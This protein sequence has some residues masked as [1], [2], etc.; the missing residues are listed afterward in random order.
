M[1]QRLPAVFLVALAA[2][3]G[4]ISCE[5]SRSE[6]PIVGVAVHGAREGFTAAFLATV[7]KRADGRVALAVMD[8]KGD[9]AAQLSQ[10]GQLVGMGAKALIVAP[11][12]DAAAAEVI[13]AAKAK[14][15]PLVLVGS[16]PRI[17]DL[18]S[19]DRV[20]FVGAERSQAGSLQGEILAASWKSRPGGDANRD[21]RLGLAF[22]GSRFDPAAKGRSED[23]LDALERAGVQ[24]DTV[25]R[26]EGRAAI[27]T[28]VA[29]SGAAIEAV[30]AGDDAS[31]SW[32]ADALESAARA[33]GTS[34]DRARVPIV[35]LSLGAAAP[36]RDELDKGRFVGTIMGDP[37][38][39]GRSALDLA[40]AL[41]SGKDPAE[42]G[43]SIAD[44]KRVPVAYAKVIAPE[45][46]ASR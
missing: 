15:V 14:G 23:C 30:V 34:P 24:A 3:V 2:T 40:Y 12:E 38:V 11:A 36:P 46:K 16:E 8:G 33:K 26:A 13:A 25:G 41:A 19:W 21:G 29:G 22:V 9:R 20:F 42:S 37:A 32:A 27:A 35:A 44:A 45:G 7:E 43:L 10:V 6:R 4:L 17:E 31:A 5:Q 28:L 1:Q 39:L 18:R